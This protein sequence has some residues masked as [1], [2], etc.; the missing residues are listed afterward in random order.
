LL[1]G[2][3][4][5]T[6]GLPQLRPARGQPRAG[7][8]VAGARRAVRSGAGDVRGRAPRLRPLRGPDRGRPAEVAAAPAAEQP[9]QRRPLPP[10]PQAGRGPRGAAGRR[11]SVRGGRPAAPRPGDPGP[12]GDRPGAVRCH[13]AGL[14]AAA[15]GPPAGYRLATVRGAAV[16]RD[17]SAAGRPV[18]GG[19][20]LPVGAGGRADGAVAGGVG[21]SP[22]DD[23][24]SE[25]TLDC[26]LAAYGEALVTGRPQE[27]PPAESLPPAL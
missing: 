27:T 1:E 6:G 5:A 8:A 12:P 9:R 16:R 23:P 11:R 17:R 7:P 21:M 19:G 13:P 22:A 2:R 24:V 15:R 25:D 18:G 10:G 20:P 4:P 26:L 3:W 14:A